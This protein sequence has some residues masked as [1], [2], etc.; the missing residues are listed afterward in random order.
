MTPTKLLFTLL[1]AGTTH[2][3]A[4][5]QFFSSGDIFINTYGTDWHDESSCATLGYVHYAVTVSNSQYGDTFKL[6]QEG[7]YGYNI[8]TKVNT[9]GNSTWTFTLDNDYP[10][11]FEDQ[12]L[13][14][15]PGNNTFMWMG[16]KAILTHYASSQSVSDT[17]HNI[18]YYHDFFVP[19]PCLY[20]EV[21]GKVYFD[22][23]NDCTFNTGDVPLNAV[24][25]TLTSNVDNNFN[26]SNTGGNYSVTTR[27]TGMTSYQ[28]KLPNF[29]QF[30][31]QSTACSPV[32][33]NET[34]LPQTNKDFS[35][36]CEDI[37][38]YAIAN[39]PLRAQPNDPFRIFTG[40]GNIGC[41]PQSGQVKLKLD[42]RVT[43]S[44]GSTVNPA[45]NVVSSVD[46]DTLVWNFSNLSSLSNGAYF[47]SFLSKVQVTPLTSVTIGDTL[48]FYCSTEIPTDDVHPGNNSRSFFVVI[49]AAYD[50][51]FKEVEPA[52]LTDQ[53]FVPSSTS[54]LT[55]T[56]HF[57]NTGTASAG[58]VY[59]IDTLDASIEPSSLHIELA[60]HTLTPEWL[61]P[62]V[63]KFSFYSIA[64]PHAAANEPASHGQF[65]YK[66]RLKPGLDLGTAIKNRGFIYFDWN[67]PIITNFAT[68]TLAEKPIVSTE[69]V[70]GL[71]LSEVVLNGTM[72][73]EQGA[74]LLEK[75]F[76]MSTVPNPDLSDI[77]LV[78][79]ALETSFSTAVTSLT[80]DTY[81]YVRSYATNAMGT[82]YGEEI[83][84]RTG[85]SVGLSSLMDETKIYPNPAKS[86][87]YVQSKH[88][89]HSYRLY[90]MEGKLMRQAPFDQSVIEIDFLLDGNY[91]LEVE[92]YQGFK[93]RLFFI[94]Q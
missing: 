11:I 90:S 2:C 23:N 87:L 4:F 36:Q 62:N 80:E 41:T 91:I 25:I 92:N 94:K 58:T 43:Y 18:G 16:R 44:A 29:Y 73:S 55:Y 47:N 51:N 24:A 46:G 79:P 74:P 5:S 50:P 21:S 89:L 75:G 9:T 48:R 66:V 17:V 8:E 6:N 49:A 82:T 14:N 64:L 33:Y 88:L 28:V 19:N 39:G 31:F 84:F 68:T 15:S 10:Q 61:S 52:G 30:I 37:D 7:M 32:Y 65:M 54:E 34:E 60:S 27:Q 72:V 69:L 1:I 81:Y 71:T 56:V 63:V 26:T 3:I 38:L 93:S 70:S 67:P 53:G 76:C 78:N 40:A 59:V 77:V 12:M 57:Q 85:S 42:P 83:S 20:E 13:N 22:Q 45:A 86:Q 35:L